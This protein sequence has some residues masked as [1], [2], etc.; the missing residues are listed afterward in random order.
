MWLF[1]WYV[2]KQVMFHFPL[3]VHNYSPNKLLDQ[4]ISGK[5]GV[6]WLVFRIHISWVIH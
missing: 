5:K 3:I 2:V 1:Y 4:N 6:Q